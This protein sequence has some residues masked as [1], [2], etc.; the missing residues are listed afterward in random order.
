MRGC[1]FDPVLLARARFCAFHLRMVNLL[2][3]CCTCVVLLMA[4][5]VHRVR[6]GDADVGA[7]SSAA[8]AAGFQ[9]SRLKEDLD[10]VADALK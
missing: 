9:C 3:V 8:T 10:R 4:V 6:C 5:A 2:H 7:P 1:A